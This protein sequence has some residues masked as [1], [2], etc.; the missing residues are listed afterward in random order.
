MHSPRPY[1]GSVVVVHKRT[2]W[3]RAP[4]PLIHFNY[5]NKQTRTHTR[6]FYH[7]TLF[8]RFKIFQTKRSNGKNK[9]SA[10]HE[11]RSRPRVWFFRECCI[12]FETCSGRPEKKMFYYLLGDISMSVLVFVEHFCCSTSF[13]IY[14]WYKFF[15]FFFFPVQVSFI[16]SCHD[17]YQVVFVVNKHKV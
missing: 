12:I 13:L 14:F 15:D 3:S 6:A 2:T 5:V 8:S 11:P 17:D 9:W 10:Q 4:G 16:Y 1:R 7:Y